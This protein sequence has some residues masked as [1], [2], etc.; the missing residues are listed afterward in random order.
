VLMRR[1]I[2][3]TVHRDIFEKACGKL[4]FIADC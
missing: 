1:A 2:G 4:R 3:A